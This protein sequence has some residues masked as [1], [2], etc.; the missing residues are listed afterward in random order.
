MNNSEVG[1]DIL[2]GS[3]NSTATCE[4]IN[5]PGLDSPETKR[6]E[7]PVCSEEELHIELPDGISE[8]KRQQKRACCEAEAVW[9]LRGV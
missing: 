7:G 2:S 3:E 9:I 6:G 8:E 1:C 4:R 5:S